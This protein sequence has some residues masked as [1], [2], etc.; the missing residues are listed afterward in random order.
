[1]AGLQIGQQISNQMMKG[2]NQELF[3]TDSTKTISKENFMAGFILSLIHI[4]L[5]LAIVYTTHTQ[6]IEYF[7][8]CHLF[9]TVFP[10]FVNSRSICLLYT[11]MPNTRRRQDNRNQPAATGTLHTHHQRKNSHPRRLC[12]DRRLPPLR[13]LS[14]IHISD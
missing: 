12:I 6:R 5:H 10:E 8:I 1:M 3:G 7:L 4:S 2:I 9:Y 14:L 11:S 13:A